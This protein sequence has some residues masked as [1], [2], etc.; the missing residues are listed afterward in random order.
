[1]FAAG[2]V[3]GEV[4]DRAWLQAMLDFEAAL[5]RASAKV[6]IVPAAA[7]EEIAAACRAEL[8]DVAALGQASADAGNPAAP[9]VKALTAQVGG[10]AAGHVHRGATSQDVVDTAAMLVSKRALAPL[11][12]D[13]LASADVCAKLADAHRHTII[14]GRTLLQQAAPL[15]FGVKAAGWLVSLGEAYGHL[16]YVRDDRLAVQLGGA[17]GTLA[18]LGDHGL[19]VVAEVAR[20][21]DLREPTLPWHSARGRVAVL[22]A[23]LGVTVGVFKK[24]AVD[25]IL[26]AQTEVAEARESETE[27]RGGSSTM[28]Q[29]QN[30]V[31][32][33]AV[34]ACAERVPGL[35]ATLLATMG[36]EHERAAGAWQAEW[37]TLS[38]LLRLAGSAA[39]HTRR[40][41]EGLE[42]DPERMRE[43]LERSD[44]LLLAESV[45][46]ALTPTLGRPRANELVAE[47][48]RQAAAGIPFNEALL[49][50]PELA[51]QLGAAGVADALS[52]ENYLG[53][54]SILID[55]ALAAH[56]SG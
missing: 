39:V 32:A 5:A 27:G 48:S 53:V 2:P 56:S 52:P 41:L 26:L 40:F 19:E 43:N 8:Y 9:L 47:A 22:G 42:L 11:L 54:S 14:A 37:E 35:V 55:R 50:V 4:D 3:A 23:M 51:E 36:Q 46:T 49:A 10:E 21:L 28:P 7:A 44:G 20:E 31:G 24:I 38:D 30:P 33:M 34:V 15:P 25:V 29:K 13:L 1:M 16:V 18:A 45:V 12:R 6:G 17:V